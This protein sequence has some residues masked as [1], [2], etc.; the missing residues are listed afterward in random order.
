[1]S[2]KLCTTVEVAKTQGVP[3]ATLQFWIASGKLKAPKVQLIGGRAVRLWNEADIESVR[4][5]KGKL[6]PGPRSRKKK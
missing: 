4:K 1:M 5:L 6:K 2:Q 3:R